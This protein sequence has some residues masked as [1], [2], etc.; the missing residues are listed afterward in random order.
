MKAE[1]KSLYT[2]LE[3]GRPGDSWSA[4][5]KEEGPLY[6]KNSETCMLN[7][8]SSTIFVVIAVLEQRVF[9]V[10]LQIEKT[11][12]GKQYLFAA[13]LTLSCFG[14]K[15]THNLHKRVNVKENSRQKQ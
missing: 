3:K 2:I 1:H 10:H 6:L 9:V 7:Y 11:Q 13:S 4:I 15:T 12:C 5:S 8:L 14:K